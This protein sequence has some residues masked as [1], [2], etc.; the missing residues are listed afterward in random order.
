MK[1]L[2][3]EVKLT[4]DGK[5]VIVGS[6]SIPIYET[7]DELAEN[8]TGEN[9]LEQFNKGNTISI[10][11]VERNKHKP[12]TAGKQKRTYIGLSLITTE[13]FQS[14]GGDAEKIKELID[15]TEIQ[16]RIDEFIA[17]QAE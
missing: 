13:E 16:A 12:A 14:T 2:V 9:I 6:V 11:N 15:S 7:V 17:S 3:K 1:Q 5:K 10:M 8:V 4:K